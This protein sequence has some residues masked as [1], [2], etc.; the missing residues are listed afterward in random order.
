MVAA[1]AER[2]PNVQANYLGFTVEHQG[3]LYQV[4]LKEIRRLDTLWT[5]AGLTL[6]VSTVPQNTRAITLTASGDPEPS[7]ASLRIHSEGTPPD[8]ARRL[9][10][11]GVPGV[12][13]ELLAAVL[14][15]IW[16]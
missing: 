16:H 5:V 14:Y 12:D 3:Q 2:T 8:I 9:R 11:K 6:A 15:R 10:S 13:E 1:G 4:C 7:T